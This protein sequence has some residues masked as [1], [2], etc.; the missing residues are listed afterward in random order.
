MSG[1]FYHSASAQASAIQPAIF[2]LDR[3][4]G[5]DYLKRLPK[6]TDGLQPAW[7]GVKVM[8]CTTIRAGEECGFM[9]ATGCSF[10]GGSC[11]EAIE[12]CQGCGR[13][14]EFNGGLYCS[15][16]MNPAIKWRLGRCNLA[17]HVKEKIEIDQIMLNPLKAS[18]RSMGR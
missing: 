6:V 3:P 12:Q 15:T 1:N 2:F 5:D 4:R 16:Y 8:E 13:V 9:K 7:K 11:K 17:T 10:N 14:V 18:K